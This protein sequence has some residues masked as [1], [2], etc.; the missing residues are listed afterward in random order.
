MELKEKFSKMYKEYEKYCLEHECTNK[1]SFYRN[2]EKCKYDDY[3][4]GLIDGKQIEE[5]FLEFDAHQTKEAMFAYQCDKLECDLQC[6][7]YVN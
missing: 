6:K 5:L 7:L 3:N 1:R 4:R 2:K